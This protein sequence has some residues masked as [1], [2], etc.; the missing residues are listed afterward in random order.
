MKLPGT[1]CGLQWAAS[2][3]AFLSSYNV[4]RLAIDA[5]N[6]QIAAIVPF[7]DKSLGHHTTNH[8]SSTISPY[9]RSHRPPYG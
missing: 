7:V 9:A 8:R 5:I 4:M 6:D 3:N 1:S 2:R